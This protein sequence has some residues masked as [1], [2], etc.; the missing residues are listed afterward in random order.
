MVDFV[1]DVREWWSIVRSRVGVSRRVAGRVFDVRARAQLCP[2]GRFAFD[3]MRYP[4]ARGF[5]VCA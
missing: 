4:R 1:V 3:R 5:K 2:E